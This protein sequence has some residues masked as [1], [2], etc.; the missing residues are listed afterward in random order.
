MP[1]QVPNEVIPQVQD[2]LR[3]APDQPGPLV[4]VYPFDEYHQMTFAEPSRTSEPFFGDWFIRSAITNGLPLNTVVSTRSLLATIPQRPELYRGS[5][6]ITPVPDA[7]SE[8]SRV[9]LDYVQRQVGRV[10]LYGPIGQAD[11]QLLAALGVRAAKPIAG[12]LEVVLDASCDTLRD[13]AYPP[14]LLHRELMCAGGYDAVLD[15][16]ATTAANVLATVSVAGERRVAGVVQAPQTWQGGVIAWVRGTNAASYGE[17]DLI[18]GRGHLPVAD[19][20]AKYFQADLLMRFA[21]A[22]M[23]EEIGVAKRSA[24]QPN[25][26]TCIAR[27]DN[28]FIFSGYV[29]DMTV[30]LRFRLSH[31]A[32]IF[33][34]FDA[35]L[36]DGRACYRMPR[37]WRRECRV[38]VEQA[39]GVVSCYER[40]AEMVGLKRRLR[41]A[42]LSNAT[43]RVFPENT[44][45]PVAGVINGSYS[46]F[47]GPFAAFQTISSPVGQYLQASGV[48]GELIL[49]W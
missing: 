6:L 28:A 45:R 40:T 46:Y 32:P 15:S 27:H 22:V 2:G 25:P 11:P 31:G 13:I 10:L 14:Q 4:W 17:I 47:E 24:G 42:G 34:G 44:D 5:I 21:C 12:E 48:T 49:S 43:V 36:I 37:A 30:G 18:S 39:D 20:P 38:F 7:G 35:E 41:V 33:V 3:H 8:L 19:D 9:L 1:E 26:I 16:T 29:P 23:G